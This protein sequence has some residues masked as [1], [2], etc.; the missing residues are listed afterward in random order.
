MRLL[1]TLASLNVIKKIIFA[2]VKCG[3]Q[4]NKYLPIN[5]TSNDTVAAVYD[6]VV[7][8]SKSVNFI[9]DLLLD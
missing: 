3:D 5:L 6:T 8:N 2:I 9:V 4:V 1:Y 7:L